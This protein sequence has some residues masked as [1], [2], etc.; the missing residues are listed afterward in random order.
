M[1]IKSFLGKLTHLYLPA[2]KLG[3]YHF[4]LLG[5]FE[6]TARQVL[7][8]NAGDDG[9]RGWHTA[10]KNSC[11]MALISSCPLCPGDVVLS[12]WPNGTAPS[13][14]QALAW[15]VLSL[16]LSRSWV[17]SHN[18]P[19]KKSCKHANSAS[20]IPWSI[21][22]Y[23]KMRGLPTKTQI[24]HNIAA[25]RRVIVHLRVLPGGLVPSD[26]TTCK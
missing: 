8:R 25:L 12:L 7:C 11:R 1:C 26:I 6:E 16:N 20:C 19:Q 21:D 14:C 24:C 22:F 2:W 9:C 3:L 15:A 23:N 10:G 5:D 13:M 4:H 17:N 18:L